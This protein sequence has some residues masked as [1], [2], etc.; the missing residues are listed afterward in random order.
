MN[1]Q[2]GQRYPLRVY[3]NHTE[4]N[5]IYLNALSNKGFKYNGLYCTYS[6]YNVTRYV[7]INVSLIF[8][9]TE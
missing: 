4:S 7:K 2:R 3:H 8:H 1:E 9:T 6:L 5:N